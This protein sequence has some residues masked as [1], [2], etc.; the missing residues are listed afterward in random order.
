MGADDSNTG[1]LTAQVGWVVLRSAVASCCSTF[2]RQTC[3]NLTKTLSWWLT[4]H[5]H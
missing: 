1:G 3:W 4:A 5:C 2:T